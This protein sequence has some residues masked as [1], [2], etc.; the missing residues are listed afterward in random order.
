MDIRG[1]YKQLNKPL[2][3][4]S[5]VASFADSTPSTLVTVDTPVAFFT[6][7][8]FIFDSVL[9]S[10]VYQGTYVNTTQFTINTA[11]NG[12]DAGVNVYDVTEV[13]Q[14]YIQALAYISS[15]PCADPLDPNFYNAVW[16]YALY[17]YSGATPEQVKRV[18]ISGEFETEYFQNKQGDNTYFNIANDLLGGCLTA[19]QKKTA[20]PQMATGKAWV[21]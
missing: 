12:D 2:V 1:A 3:P 10:D 18:K 11:F 17:L 8:Y 20:I 7:G 14:F 13:Y 5:T 21:R 4:L 15:L 16:W 9:Y 19:S 6:Q